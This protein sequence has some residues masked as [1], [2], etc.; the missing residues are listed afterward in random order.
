F[1]GRN[2]R[3]KIS[4]FFNDYQILKNYYLLYEEYVEEAKNNSVHIQYD[5]RY[6][7]VKGYGNVKVGFRS[8]DILSDYDFSAVNL[9]MINTTALGKLDLKTRFFAQWGD[10][11]DIPF[12]SSL[13]FAGAN[14]EE[15]LES[16]FTY[17][18]GLFPD[19]W[20]TFGTTTSHFHIG[21][22][23]NVR[24]YSGYLIAQE[25]RDGEIYQVYTGSS[26][27]SISMEL[28]F[29][30]LVRRQLISFI[31][32]DPYLFADAG[33]IVYEEI[34]GKNYFS[35]IR[36]D[37]GIGSAFTWSWWGPLETVKPLTVRI[38]FPFFL[39]RP[40]YEETDYIKFRYVVGI[41]RA[42]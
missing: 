33:S 9:E 30:R 23:L 25:G 39:N 42:F 22:G 24:G 17:A 31:K 27:S 2:N 19:E 20:T 18:R 6:D 21:G 12:E 11:T 14:Q 4:V 15:L 16:K 35:D 37:A 40:P 28:E 29:D 5:H 3:N 34:N 8:N 10:G 36:M 38:D 41:N 1:I 32:M 13:L 7:Y 26:G